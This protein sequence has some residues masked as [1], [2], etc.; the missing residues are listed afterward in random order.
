ML[1]DQG[2]FVE[3]HSWSVDFGLVPAAQKSARSRKFALAA[4]RS[5]DIVLIL[6][7]FPIIGPFLLAVAGLIYVWD[8]GPVLFLHKRIG[9]DGREFGC[10]KF[11]TMVTDSDAALARH[12]AEN[13]EARREWER[14]QKLTDDPRI[15]PVIGTFLRKFSLDELP[16]IYNV[17]TGDMSLIGPRP[18]TRDELGRYGDAARYYLA[19]RPGVSGKWQVSGRSQTTYE[20]R[21]QMD[22]EYVQNW[23]LLGD[24][25]ILFRTVGVVLSQDGAA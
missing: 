6:T 20:E 9:R 3:R 21:V 24:L 8:G 14:T 5:I 15:L 10:L 4:K 22:L 2:A 11:R 12:L 7:A 25:K 1:D 16:Q 18:V 19:V 17:L 23:T 13:P